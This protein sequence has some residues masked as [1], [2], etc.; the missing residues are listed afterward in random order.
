MYRKDDII[1]ANFGVSAQAGGGKKVEINLQVKNKAWNEVAKAV[2]ATGGVH[3]T[4]MK[5]H[6][7]W[8]DLKSRA[9]AKFMKNATM[10]G[11]GKP[12]KYTKWEQKVI[13]L[14]E[15]HKSKLLRGMDGYNTGKGQ[16][17]YLSTCQNN[18]MNAL[19]FEL[20]ACV[21]EIQNAFF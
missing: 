19:L 18:D 17:H 3:R 8:T 10:T 9:L 5:V 20:C 7:N 4:V 1:D 15:Q 13:D 21:H 14:K 12:I 2:V 6:R 16:V 11:G